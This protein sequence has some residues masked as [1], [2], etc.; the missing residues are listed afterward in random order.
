V[1]DFERYALRI[2]TKQKPLAVLPIRARPNKEIS[3]SDNPR[4]KSE[5]YWRIAKIFVVPILAI[6]ALALS[7]VNS[8][9]GKSGG[10][11]IAFLVY[12]VYSNLLNYGVAAVQKGQIQGPY[13]IWLVHGIFALLAM[14]F[15]YRRSHRLKTNRMKILDNYLRKAIL[16]QFLLVLSVLMALFI[17]ITFVDE[18]GSVNRGNYGVL[19]ITQFV[20]LSTPKIMYE[21]FPIAALIGAIMGLANLAKESELIVI[22]SIGVSINQIIIST[23]K[24]GAILGVAGVIIGEI[25]AP[26]TETKAQRPYWT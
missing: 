12:F 23:L 19:K 1:I 11:M 21:V 14:F 4:M 7:Y 20:I 18:L 24:T 10:M 2:E 25:I 26:I 13:L 8:R 17:F 9:S 16:N 5:W 22:R 15:L 6:F 3:S